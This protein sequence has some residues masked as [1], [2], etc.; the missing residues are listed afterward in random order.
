MKTICP[1]CF[2]E[3][4][5]T[6]R[7]KKFHGC[8]ESKHR[9]YVEKWRRQKASPEYLQSRRD[10]YQERAAECRGVFHKSPEII[11]KKCNKKVRTSNRWFCPTCHEVI[12]RGIDF[13]MVHD[14]GKSR[15]I[16]LEGRS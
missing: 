13:S 5:P 9:Q 14:E 4:E 12:S 8:R 1:D 16:V 10:Y 11:C 15:H 6:V 7:Q 3:W 2:Q